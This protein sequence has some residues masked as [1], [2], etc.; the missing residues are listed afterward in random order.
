MRATRENTPANAEQSQN[1]E[2]P[3]VR[4]AVTIIRYL[5]G[6]APRGAS[7]RETAGDLG[8][9]TSHC[10]NILR[11]L[12]GHDWV[13]YDTQTRH[14]QLRA[15]LYADASA[16]FAQFEPIADLRPIISHLTSVIG[17][18]C[19]LS[20]VEPDGTFLVIDKA[21]GTNGLGITVPMGHRFSADAPVQRKAVL[22]WSSDEAI[23][24]WLHRWRPVAYTITSITDRDALLEELRATRE[25]GYAVSREEYLTGVTSVSLPIFDRAAMPVMVLQCPAL[26]ESLA[27]RERQ[28][29]KALQNAVT[30]AHAVLGSRVPVSFQFPHEAAAIMPPE[31]AESS[32]S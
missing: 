7:L 13:G 20:Q 26:T 29:A 1:G 27:P 8:I 2:V 6:R 11:T 21:D 31:K 5:N 10:H 19:I 4:K 17:L 16:A 24:S 23:A 30:R 3:A 28:V 32:A 12:M 15:G 9:T 22:A 25:R 18:T 14:Y